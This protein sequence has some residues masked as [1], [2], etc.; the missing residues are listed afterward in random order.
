M[1]TVVKVRRY[2]GS[3]SV[4][5]IC[6][7]AESAVTHADRCNM[8]YQTDAYY[9]E[10]WDAK[11]ADELCRDIDSVLRAYFRQGSQA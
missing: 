4:V 1:K 10:P 2:D 7:D 6:R 11:K 9:A 5:R 3:E 8:E